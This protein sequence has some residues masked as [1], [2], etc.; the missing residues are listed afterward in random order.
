M[1]FQQ[2]KSRGAGLS[3]IHILAGGRGVDFP[4]DSQPLLDQLLQAPAGAVAGEHGQIVKMNVSA[5]VGSGNFRIID[6]TEP[7]IGGDGAGVGERC[8]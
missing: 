3:L 5:F 2:G 8:V 7:V 4:G 1:L 6:L